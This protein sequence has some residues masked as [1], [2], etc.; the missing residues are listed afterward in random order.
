MHRLVP[1]RL[2]TAQDLDSGGTVETGVIDL[3]TA[4]L[5]HCVIQI[6]QSGGDAD[7]KIQ[8]AISID[9]TTFNDYDSQE[10]IIASTNTEWTGANPED[11]HSFL[12]A[13]SA[14]FI[15]LKLTELAT[16]NDNTIT[17]TGYL[18]E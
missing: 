15:K 1:L 18:K 8:A 7:V 5:D 16:L 9:G 14:P 12:V 2:L 3:R 4:D 13:V 11:P 10:D 6:V 17:L